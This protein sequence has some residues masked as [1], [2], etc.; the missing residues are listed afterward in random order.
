MFSSVFDSK[1]PASEQKLRRPRTQGSGQFWHLH[2][3]LPF[4][5]LKMELRARVI[6]T[7]KAKSLA[8]YLAHT[9]HGH[10][11]LW[12]YQYETP[13]SHEPHFTSEGGKQLS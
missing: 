9:G 4:L 2:L 8:V 10:C 5:V 13:D 6:R 7:D 11:Q 1:Y 12:N 3:S